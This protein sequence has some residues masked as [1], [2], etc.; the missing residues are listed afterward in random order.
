MA[1]AVTENSAAM[2]EKHGGE[3]PGPIE[4]RLWLRL[5]SCSMTVEKRLRRN[6]QDEFGTTLPRFDVL[7]ALDRAGDAGLTMG[8]LSR[9]LLVSNGNVT[10]IIRHL[11][12]GGFV[13]SKAHPKDGRTTL[14][15]LTDEGQQ[16]F[17][18]LAFAHHK[19]ICSMFEG[20]PHDK[21]QILFEVLDE[22]RATIGSHS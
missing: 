12:D 14:V 20:F 4:V 13:E 22:L 2:R 17:D 11:Q 6:F 8:Q 18:G 3:M 1:T 16:H 19:W 15:K 10:S 7:A 5:L 21:Q 9:S